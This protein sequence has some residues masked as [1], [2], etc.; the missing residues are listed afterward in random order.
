MD[1]RRLAEK[2]AEEMG[3]ES[4]TTWSANATAP[5]AW[6]L[7]VWASKEC[8]SMRRIKARIADLWCKLMHTAPMWPAYGQYECRTCGRRH[9]VCWEQSRQAAPRPIAKPFEEHVQTLMVTTV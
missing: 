9:R 6:K 2:Q 1:W 4:C 3:R 5:I 8:E 7:P